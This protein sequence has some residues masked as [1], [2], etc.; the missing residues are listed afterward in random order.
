[1]KIKSMFDKSDAFSMDRFQKPTTKANSE[2][3]EMLE[4]FLTKMNPDRIASGYKPITPARIG[5]MLAHVPT[6]DL[7]PF[8]KEC[9]QAKSFGA[10]FHWKLR[11]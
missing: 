3:A 11:K 7:F 10:L 4:K 9:E 1:M 8:F 2:R 5:V 6:S